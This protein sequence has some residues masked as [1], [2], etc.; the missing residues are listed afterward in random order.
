MREAVNNEQRK[1]GEG[2]QEGGYRSHFW[3]N[4]PGKIAQ[5]LSQPCPYHAVVAKLDW[6]W[7]AE[8][9]PFV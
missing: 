2:R 3:K 8:N 4:G 7:I 1:I 6:C 5:G 9:L